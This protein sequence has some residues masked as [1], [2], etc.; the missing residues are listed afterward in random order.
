MILFLQGN[1][2]EKNT[3]LKKELALQ[4]TFKVESKKLADIIK[5][6]RKYI[7]STLDPAPHVESSTKET[8][9]KTNPVALKKK[10]K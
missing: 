8:E 7:A 3:S 2:I 9:F 1:L 10:V 4:K 5:P 6:E